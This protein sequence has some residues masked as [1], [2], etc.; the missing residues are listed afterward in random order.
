[1]PLHVDAASGGF[2]WP[3]LDPHSEWDFRLEQVRSINV[4]GHKF[5]PVYPGIGWLI[6]SEKAD[7]PEDL[8][9]YEN[10]LGKRDADVHAQLLHRL[11]H[12]PRAVLQLRP[13]L[14]RRLPAS[15]W[16]R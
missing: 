15:S 11:D 1:M 7:L 8:V 16:R 6:F 13:L 4:S 9:F 3:F 10:H 5:G 12:G 2:V 14:A